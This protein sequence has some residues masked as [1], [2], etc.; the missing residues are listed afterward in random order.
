VPRDD[1][2][3]E[4]QDDGVFDFDR[5]PT[6]ITASFRTLRTRLAVQEPPIRKLLITSAL[7]SEGKTTVAINL[8]A[9][10]AQAANSVVVVDANLDNP[11]VAKRVGSRDRPGLTDAIRGAALRDVIQRAVGG[12]DTLA[13]LGAGTK[14][15]DHPGDL[16]SSAA[17]REVLNEL[18]QQ[19]DYVIVD[20]AA[21][22][23]NSGTE[24]I[25]PSVHG[26][27]LVSRQSVAT[28]T[29]LVECR[30]RLGNAQACVTGLVFFRSRKERT[31][32]RIKVNA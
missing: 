2:R 28:M 26:V 21:L 31:N 6:E 17:F 14:V 10:L 20:S 22:L 29:D 1:Q 9:V 12:V 8:G 30:T 4:D 27:L 24:A 3:R 25:L 16:F 19:F 15:S 5:Q 11:D 32:R 7:P 23:E 18:S 13:V